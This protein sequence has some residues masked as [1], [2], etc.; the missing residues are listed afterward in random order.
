MLRDEAEVLALSF[1]EERFEKMFVKIGER[2]INLTNVTQVVPGEYDGHACIRID[3]VGG[4]SYRFYSRDPGYAVL[5][6][7][8]AEQPTL[9]ND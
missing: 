7:W 5:Q 4:D 1:L 8:L 2:V 6:T 3:F 9:L